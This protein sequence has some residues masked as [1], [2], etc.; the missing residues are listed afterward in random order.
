MGIYWLTMGTPSHHKFIL[1]LKDPSV[2]LE[3]DNK[4]ISIEI[5]GEIQEIKSDYYFASICGLFNY[6]FAN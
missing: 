6:L 2:E 1:K 3:G 5:R 4:V